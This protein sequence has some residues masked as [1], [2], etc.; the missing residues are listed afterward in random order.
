MRAYVRVR[1]S[2]PN[3]ALT[4]ERRTTGSSGYVS[5]IMG[6]SLE[7][8]RG[9]PRSDWNTHGRCSSP[10]LPSVRTSRSRG[11]R[12]APDGPEQGQRVSVQ[13]AQLCRY[14]VRSLYPSLSTL[15]PSN[16]RCSCLSFFF[17]SPVSECS[18]CYGWKKQIARARVA[19]KKGSR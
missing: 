12:G 17:L 4:C 2:A 8:A 1:D 9:D 5:A 3:A 13:E 15:D 7:P 6:R 19:A 14:G 10:L 11:P 18:K 16:K